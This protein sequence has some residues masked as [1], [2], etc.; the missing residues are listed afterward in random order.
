MFFSSPNP[1]YVE[2]SHQ[3][4]PGCDETKPQPSQPPVTNLQV[5]D[6][7][8]PGTKPH[9]ANIPDDST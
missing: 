9:N 6:L 5:Q 4:D 3:C 2:V 7:D 1:E 8:A